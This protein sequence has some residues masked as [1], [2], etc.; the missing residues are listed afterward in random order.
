MYSGQPETK[1]CTHART[2]AFPPYASIVNVVTPQKLH[3]AKD[4]SSQ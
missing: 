2:A 3:V 4:A 1:T